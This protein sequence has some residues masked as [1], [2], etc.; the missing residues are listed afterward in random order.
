MESISRSQLIE[1]LRA[2]ETQCADNVE[3]F[4]RNEGW[5]GAAKLASHRAELN[6]VR[7]FLA[8]IAPVATKPA[9]APR[10]AWYRE[11]RKTFACARQRGLNL[12]DDA[13]MRR[14]FSRYLGREVASR[15]TLNGREWADVADGVKAGLLT[16]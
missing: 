11:V 16:W 5:H 7:A 3:F 10:C 2:Y 14:A 9:K 13:G 15:E 8:Q 12:K 1:E 4:E 6:A